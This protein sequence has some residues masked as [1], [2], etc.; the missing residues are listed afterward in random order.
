MCVCVCVCMCMYV[1]VYLCVHARA[2]VCVTNTR[3]RI[4]AGVQSTGYMSAEYQPLVVARSEPLVD[5]GL[6]E[7]EQE[8]KVALT[9]V[10]FFDCH[11]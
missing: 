11:Y 2:C 10:E 9:K 1:Y 3:N 6:K 7:L 4:N 5:E 8:Y